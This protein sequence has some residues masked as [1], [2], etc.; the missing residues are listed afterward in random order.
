MHPK[1]V[2]CNLAPQ[3]IMQL[4]ASIQMY[5]YGAALRQWVGAEYLSPAFALS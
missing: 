5:L 3:Q 4:F 2:N 1:L